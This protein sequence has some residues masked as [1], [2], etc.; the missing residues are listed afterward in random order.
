M[1]STSVTVTGGI[2]TFFWFCNCAVGELH[3]GIAKASF[4]AGFIGHR[5]RP[6]HGSAMELD[7]S[8]PQA[9]SGTRNG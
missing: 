1:A 5:S 9:G 4:A 8:P 3:F 6:G 7:E 2:N